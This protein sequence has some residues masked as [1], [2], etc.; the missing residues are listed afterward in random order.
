MLQIFTIPGY[1][2]HK[3]DVSYQI[4]YPSFQFVF[5]THDPQACF[6][7]PIPEMENTNLLLI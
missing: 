6:P 3:E 7:N 5:P 2:F 4:N 1:I